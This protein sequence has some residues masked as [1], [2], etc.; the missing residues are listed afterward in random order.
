MTRFF[1]FALMLAVP[2][3]QNPEDDS[4]RQQL[5]QLMSMDCGVGEAAQRFRATLAASGPENTGLLLDFLRNGAPQSIERQARADAAEQFERLAAW[6]QRQPDKPHAKAFAGGMTK[7]AYI[8]QSIDTLGLTFRSNALRG[9][10]IIGTADAAAAISQAV[11]RDPRL[12]HLGEE[13][14]RNVRAR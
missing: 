9:L 4:V 5:T 6:A 12:S 1:I 11:E 7:E 10:S 13:A 2:F 3:L 8:A 14:L